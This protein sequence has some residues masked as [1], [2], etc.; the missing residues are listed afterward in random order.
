MRALALN[1][2]GLVS[3]AIRAVPKSDINVFKKLNINQ[4]FTETSQFGVNIANNLL[5]VLYRKGHCIRKKVLQCMVLINY[6]LVQI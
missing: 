1:P 5:I 3:S 2:C 4:N 6:C